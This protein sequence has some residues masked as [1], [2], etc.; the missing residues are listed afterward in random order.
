M[1]N[2][3]ATYRG[4]LADVGQS[5]PKGFRMWQAGFYDFNIYTEKKLVEKLN[6]MYSNPVR[7]GLASSPSDYQWSSCTRQV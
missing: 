7:A 3:G 6:Y 1:F 2:G 4:R 5:T